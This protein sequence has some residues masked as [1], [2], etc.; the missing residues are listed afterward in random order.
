MQVLWSAVL[1]SEVQVQ[2]LWSGGDETSNRN[3][4]HL[5]AAMFQVRPPEVHRLS[6]HLLSIPTFTTPFLPIPWHIKLS[7][8]VKLLMKASPYRGKNSKEKITVAH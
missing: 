4:A 6:I 7:D 3:I 8:E 1:C 2:V 5:P